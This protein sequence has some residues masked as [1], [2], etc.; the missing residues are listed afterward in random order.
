[1]CFLEIKLLAKNLNYD[2]GTFLPMTYFFVVSKTQ[3]HLIL[4]ILL[5]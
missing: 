5:F 3:K 2:S 1:M 4:E